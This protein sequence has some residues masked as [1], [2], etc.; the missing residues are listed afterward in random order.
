MSQYS[1]IS[2]DL[3]DQTAVLT[4]RRGRKLNALT[5]Q[6][7]IE[8]F[9][10]LNTIAEDPGVKVVVLTGE[11]RAFSAGY[12][13]G[14]GDD[15][16]VRTAP[17]WKHHFHLAFRTLRRIW[18]L[19][20]PVVS[21]VRGACLGGG[22]ALCMASDLAY[23]SDDAFFGDPEIKFGGNGNLFPVLQWSTGIKKLHEMVLTGRTID[24]AEA[25]AHG[26]INEV[27][28]PDELDA[29]VQQIIRH[30]SLLP[31]GTLSTN[32]ANARGLYEAMGLSTLIAMSENESIIGLSS[33]DEIEFTRISKEQG[34]TAALQWQK[35]RFAEVG[36]FS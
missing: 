4:L 8:L 2:C 10:A 3:E 15:M 5:D 12:D 11:G 23:A 31:D 32:K 33:R 36:A 14:E 9:A 22:L 20:Q 24:A 17:Y 18:T 26:L 7:N 1:Q 30:M 29:R 25:K 13:V 19:P 16:P 34:V 28:S 35:R 27:L 6:I 21:K